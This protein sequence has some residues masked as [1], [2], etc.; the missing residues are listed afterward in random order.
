MFF[1][2]V[3]TMFVDQHVHVEYDLTTPRIAVHKKKWKVH[4]NTVYWW[5]FRI[6]QSKGLQVYQTGSN[7]IMLSDTLLAMCIEK[8]VSMK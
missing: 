6:A 2:V 8:V 1:T 3:K 5:I 7:A 4:Q